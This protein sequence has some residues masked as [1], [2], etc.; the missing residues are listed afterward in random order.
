MAVLRCRGI[1]TLRAARPRRWRTRQARR[2]DVSQRA[3]LRSGRRRGLGHPGL[4]RHRDRSARQHS[5]PLGRPHGHRRGRLGG[6]H[7]LVDHAHRG[8]G[9][10]EGGGTGR[11]GRIRSRRRHPRRARR[12]GGGRRG[13]P[14][15]CRDRRRA[16][17]RTLLLLAVPPHL[18]VALRAGAG[19]EGSTGSTGNRPPPRIRRRRR[20]NGSLS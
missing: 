9:R 2:K 19:A 8:T 5:R 7:F 16:C 1:R 10:G 20:T 4:R 18:E 15:H 12:H 13:A 17:L 11:G 3:R 6:D 14:S